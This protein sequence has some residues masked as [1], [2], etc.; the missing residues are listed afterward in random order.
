MLH[1]WPSD[2]RSPDGAEQP[3]VLNLLD[4][5]AVLRLIAHHQVVAFLAFQHL[6][7][8]LA[9]DCRFDRVLNVRDIDA[10][11]IRL[12]A[13][14]HQVQ[15][16]LADDPEKAQPLDAANLAHRRDNFIALLLQQLQDRCRK[17]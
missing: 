6:R 3:Y 13:I 11:A 1:S 12:G 5:A 16:R 10:E 8:G 15:I 14:D 4:G 9:A 17:S 7:D 2:T